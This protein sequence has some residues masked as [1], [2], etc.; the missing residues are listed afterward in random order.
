MLGQAP[1]PH[2]LGLHPHHLRARWFCAA[3]PAPRTGLAAAHRGTGL[4]RDLICVLGWSRQWNAD[5]R[6]EVA[7]RLRGAY[8]ASNTTDR[9][10]DPVS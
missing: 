4:V 1:A 6:A 7:H 8:M 9:T 3:R 2:I 5:E 10:F